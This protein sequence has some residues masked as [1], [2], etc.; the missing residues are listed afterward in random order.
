MLG[1]DEGADS[2]LGLG[3][4][5]RVQRHRGLAAGLGAVDLHHTTA[6]QATDAQG[7]VEGDRSGRDEGDGQ[8]GLVTE[9]H[10]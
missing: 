9:T 2:T 6:G 7:N 4:G 3:L 8:P 10:H 1:V 5:D